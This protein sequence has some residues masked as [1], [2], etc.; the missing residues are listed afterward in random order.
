MRPVYIYFDELT[1]DKENKFELDFS[2]NSEV[3]NSTL[4]SS[5]S[6]YCISSMKCYIKI[7]PDVAQSKRFKL[8]KELS[9][10]LQELKSNE[11]GVFF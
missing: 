1:F 4:F 2:Q 9:D 10:T 5:K 8:I 7:N 3:T 11:P 6:D